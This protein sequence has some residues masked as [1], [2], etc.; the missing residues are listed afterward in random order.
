MKTKEFYAGWHLEEKRRESR[1]SAA[2]KDFGIHDSGDFEKIQDDV[3]DQIQHSEINRIVR[4]PEIA[5]SYTNNDRG[6]KSSIEIFQS[7]DHQTNEEDINKAIEKVSS[8]DNRRTKQAKDFIGA[9]MGRGVYGYLKLRRLIGYPLDHITIPT[10][11]GIWAQKIPELINPGGEIKISE[12]SFILDNP[13]AL[14]SN[15]LLKGSGWASI[16]KG[17]IPQQK[18]FIEARGTGVSKYSNVII[19][20]IQIDGSDSS[21]ETYWRYCILTEYATNVLVQNCYGHS[22]KGGFYLALDAVDSPTNHMCVNN[23]AEGMTCCYPA[24]NCFGY[25]FIQNTT[26]FIN[27]I[28]ANNI[29]SDWAS[30]N[31]CGFYY[32][33]VHSVCVGN[34]IRMRPT[35]EGGA[36]GHN[37]ISVSWGEFNM[38]VGNTISDC[39]QADEGGIEIES[40]HG[41]VAPR[42]NLVTGNVV[43]DSNWG[44]FLRRNGG[45]EPDPSYNL[46][47]DNII[48]DCTVGFLLENS[49]DYNIFE[50]N[51]LVNCTTPIT[52]AAL[53]I[54]NIICNNM[55]YNPV[56]IS[57][58]SVGASEFTYT[59]G[60]SPETIYI[61]GG[62]VSLIKKGT[63]TIFT[64]SGHSV[65]LEPHKLCKVTYSSIPTMYKD[66]H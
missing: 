18:A 14:K 22:L 62:T 38:I 23:F 44:I 24:T 50:N 37:A 21:A 64:D 33:T 19:R 41:D 45:T 27:A 12:G 28:C 48:E 16:L 46:I 17:N 10:Y 57:S 49:P 3:I 32:G 42:Y 29:I 15:V 53:G 5:N 1:L 36:C 13:I 61:S 34:T 52:G 60:A 63:T 40:H 43:T 39:F 26:P 6:I 9:F 58:I 59:A 66:V 47:A 8:T 55:G 2:L 7:S 65:E 56:G 4:N 25:F 54:G 20:D 51:I 35:G 11:Y 30:V 31:I